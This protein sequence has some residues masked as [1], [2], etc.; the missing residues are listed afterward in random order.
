MGLV[1]PIYKAMCKDVLASKAIRTDDTPVRVLEPGARRAHLGRFWSYLGDAAH[2]AVVYQF[3]WTREQKW[4]KE[5][6]GAYKGYLQADAYPGYDQLYLTGDI[7]EVACLAH[8]RRRF[9]EALE[10]DKERALF[11]L[12]GISRLYDIEREAKERKLTAGEVRALRQERAQPILDELKA[13]LDAELLRV[14]PKS[15]IGQAIQYARAQWKAL[16]RYLED[17]DLDIDNNACE[18][19]IRGIGV[20]RRNWLF[21]G[22][23]GG[24]EWA[25]VVYSL[26]ES[27][28]LS[29]HDPYRYLKDVLVRVSSHPMNRIEELTPRL[30]KPPPNPG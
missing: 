27:A 14:L 28:K 7:I 1:R 9:F 8:I 29:G 18:R 12:T 15:P 6:L 16:L 19:T 10:T 30:W 25:A 2:L 3:T 24:G 4:A 13:W 21:L 26:I 23:E 17:G 11:M 20:G 5:F 22:S